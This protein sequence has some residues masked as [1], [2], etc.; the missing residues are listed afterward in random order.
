MWKLITF[1]LKILTHFWP[2]FSFYTPLKH[3]KLLVF[4]CF[5]EVK[6]EHSLR[7]K[8][9]YSEFSGAYFPAFGLNIQ[10]KCGKIR[11]RK[12]P[13]TDTFQQ[14]L[15][16]NGLISGLKWIMTLHLS[17]ILLP[18]SEFVV[19]NMFKLS[20]S[21]ASTYTQQTFAF[22]NLKKR[23]TKKGVKYVQS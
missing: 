19:K 21:Y 3:Q 22:S 15:S 17:P 4:W 6:W 7:E 2:M 14:W 9:P 8:C 23:N 1:R 5:H 11:T 16:R 12:T 13:N 10:S 18:V 20:S